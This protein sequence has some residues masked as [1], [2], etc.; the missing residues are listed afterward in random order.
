MHR[1]RQNGIVELLP[2]HVCDRRSRSGG[3]YLPCVKDLSERNGKYSV[4][5][6][7]SSNC[8]FCFQRIILILIFNLLDLLP[9]SEVGI[10]YADNDISVMTLDGI[11]AKYIDNRWRSNY[12]YVLCAIRWRRYYLFLG[13][14]LM[15][16]NIG[17]DTNMHINY[18]L[19]VC[20]SKLKCKS[21]KNKLFNE[22]ECCQ[23]TKVSN[24]ILKLTL[25][26]I[27]WSR[28]VSKNVF[29]YVKV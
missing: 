7:L 13:I 4:T 9:T 6:F 27:C 28:N 20:L 12:V 24:K 8:I 14:C 1:F 21:E 22:I 15:I 5:V 26:R 2:K 25:D 10:K 29:C 23:F 17:Y 18:A 19:C 16:K 11:C 3:E